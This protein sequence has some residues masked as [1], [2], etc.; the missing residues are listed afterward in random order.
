MLLLINI[1]GGGIILQHLTDII[2]IGLI[3]TYGGIW[4]DA[5]ILMI[6]S[7]PVEYGLLD[8]YSSHPRNIG[9]WCVGL[10][11][12]RDLAL[13]RT[14]YNMLLYYWENNDQLI[15]Y[16]LTD[17]MIQYCYMHYPELA[18]TIDSCPDN[19]PDL[20]WF[21][22]HRN[23]SFDLK[24]YN[25]IRANNYCFKL[26]TKTEMGKVPNTYSAHLLKDYIAI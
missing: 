25:M 13:F 9:K 8:F 5:G 14:V 12:G 6:K 10:I 4:M 17:R 7:M 11:G 1:N 22:S 24:T 2:R 15:D 26:T 3:S 20:M 16:F 19:N 18:K 21:I 23:D